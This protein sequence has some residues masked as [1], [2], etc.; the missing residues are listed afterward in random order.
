MNYYT[1]H[2]TISVYFLE[3]FT[4]YGLRKK[5]HFTQHHL[6]SSTNQL[7]GD[8]ENKYASTKQNLSISS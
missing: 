6:N 1:C 8:F 5:T 4:F 2:V 7:I 3:D